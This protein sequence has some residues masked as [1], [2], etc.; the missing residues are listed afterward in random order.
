MSGTKSTDSGV[1]VACCIYAIIISWAAA[2]LTIALPKDPNNAALLYYQA[3]VTLPE[4]QNPLGFERVVRGADPNDTS[5]KYLNRRECRETLELLQ[6]ATELPRCDWGFVYSRGLPLP[7]EILSPLMRLGVLLKVHAC[8]LAIDGRH[9]EAIEI[10]LRMRRLARHLSDETYLMYAVSSQT[11]REALLAIQYVLGCLPPD[12]RVLTWVRDQLAVQGTPWRPQEALSSFRDMSLQFRL[13]H[14][15]DFANWGVRDVRVS[16]EQSANKQA[17]PLTDRQMLDGAR[18]SFDQFLKAVLGIIESDLGC[19]QK[20]TELE[21]Q[22]NLWTG[23]A[24]KGDPILLL[25]EPVENVRG[26]FRLHMD[27]LVLT[28]AVMAALEVYLVKA[29]TGELPEVLPNNVPKDPYNGKDFTYE[30]SE[31][32]FLIRSSPSPFGPRK[33]R[34]FEF[35]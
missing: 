2:Q 26:Y 28:N 16:Q 29:R 21:R 25:M 18:R 4:P 3:C 22:E 8:T 32:G 15:K 34:Q 7:T 5:R 27:N 10:C 35:K 19:E 12:G 17:Q 6:A 14:Q 20:Q 1:P 11:D 33:T 13:A 30:R 31:R 24:S 9:K 23:Q